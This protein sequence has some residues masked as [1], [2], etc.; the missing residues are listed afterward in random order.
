LVNEQKFDV[1]ITDSIFLDANVEK[2]I[3]EKIGANVRKYQSYDPAELKEIT[4][5]ADGI[6]TAVS[7]IKKEVISNLEKARAI[8]CYGVGYDNVD[9]KAATEKGI[10]VCNVPDYLT[11]E[12]AEHAMALILSLV[13]KVPWADKFTRTAEWKKNGIRSWNNFRPLSYLD[14]KVGGIVGLGRIGSQV[15][16]M[17]QAFHVTVIASDPYVPK[18]VAEKK[19]VELVDLPTLMR[20]SDVISVN[21][22][23]SD[24]TLHLIDAEELSMMKETAIIVNTARGKIVNNEALAKVLKDKKIAGAALDVMEIEPADPGSPLLTLDNIVITPH[25]AGMSEKASLNSRRL[26]SEEMV[27]IL[28]GKPP[29]NPLNKEVLKK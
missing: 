8:V 24:E 27:R 2:E 1:V 11:Y 21:A 5:S 14:G 6:L 16:A 17:L 28:T 29:R 25:I 22:L 23:L 3:L 12:V 19:G 15:A 9:M 26:A 13:R 20:K 10:L 7:P 4:R 18:E